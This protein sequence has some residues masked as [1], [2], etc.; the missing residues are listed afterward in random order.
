V[1]SKL[2]LHSL[3]VFY[4]VASEGSITAA[5]EK[6]CLT[7]PTITYHVRSLEKNVGIKLLDIKKQKVFLTYA[8]KGLLRYV[9]EIYQQMTSAERFLEGLKEASLRVGISATFSS[10]VALAAAA[11]KEL[12]P[13]VRLIVRSTS[14]FEVVEDVLNSQVDLGVV[15]GV[16]YENHKLRQVE[17]SPREKLMLV[18]SPSSMITQKD[19]VRLSDLCGYPMV[20]GP[21]TSAT[22]R[23]LLNRLWTGGCH[24]PAPIIV[25]VN[26]L[27]WGMSLVVNGKGMSLYHSRDA[28]KGISEGR[29][30]ELVLSDDIWVAANALLR[31]DAPEHPMAEQFIALVKEAFF[32]PDQALAVHSS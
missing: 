6:L 20:L 4:H 9:R 22:R 8:G 17:L 13:H 24:M 28:E 25:E 29:L 21:E 5:A 31:V 14:S 7:Q 10:T 23:I 30:K 16:D 11:F 15:V 19:Q 12:Y 1:S 3:I 26:S 32:T 2:D 18:V 27:E